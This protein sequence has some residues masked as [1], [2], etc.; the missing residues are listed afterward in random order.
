MNDFRLPDD[1]DPSSGW[2][3][4]FLICGLFSAAGILAII[5]WPI[6]KLYLP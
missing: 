2:N 3:W 1:D 6:L 5:G 4:P